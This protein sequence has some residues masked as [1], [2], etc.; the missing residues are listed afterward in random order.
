MRTSLRL[1]VLFMLITALASCWLE[2]AAN[3]TPPFFYYKPILRSLVI[4]RH[5]QQANQLWSLGIGIGVQY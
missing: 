4:V 1:I 3:S 5:Q 2:N